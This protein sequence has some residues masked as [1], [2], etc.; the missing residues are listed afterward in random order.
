MPEAIDA[1]V[2]RTWI[3]RVESGRRE[4]VRDEVAIEE[5]LEIRVD[6]RALAVTMRTP[7]QDEELALGFLLGEGLI[8][9]GDDVADA[10]PNAELE[11]NIVEVTTRAGLR[12]DPF[13]ERRFHMTSSCGVCGKGALEQVRLELP[14][15][16]PAPVRVEPAQ[17]LGLPGRARTAQEAFDRTGGIHATGLFTPA[18]DLL[19]LREDVGRH[20][21]MDKAIGSLVLGEGAPEGALACLSGRIGFELVQKAVMAGLSGIVAVGA[22]TSLAVELAQEHGLLVCGFVREGSFNVYSGAEQVGGGT[23]G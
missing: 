1:G 18:G 2:A 12:R 8:A 9:G 14:A 21:A 3:E 6:G 19:A 4:L 7:G 22:P 16:T 10:G 5:P 11:A 23:A 13:A 20:N 15:R 17:V